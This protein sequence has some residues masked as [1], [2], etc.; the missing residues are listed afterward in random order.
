MKSS[1]EI[2]PFSPIVPGPG[3]PGVPNPAPG[4]IFRG[5]LLINLL[6]WGLLVV[7]VL[8]GEFLVLES[9]DSEEPRV[10]DGNPALLNQK[11]PFA[12]TFKI[13]LAWTALEEGLIKPETRIRCWDKHVP[14]CPG[15]IDLRTA[16]LYSSNQ[17]FV[18][19]GKKLGR[20]RIE[21][22]L[23]RGGLFAS[24]PKNWLRKGMGSV[25]SGGN[26]RISPLDQQRF[27][28]R[29]FLGDLCAPG[30]RDQLLAVMEWP[31]PRSD[32]R[33]YGKSGSAEG[34]LWFNGFG[35]L[36]GRHRFVTVFRQG[37]LDDRLQV[38]EQ[39]YQ[40]FGGGYNHALLYPPAQ[41]PAG[42][43]HLSIGDMRRQ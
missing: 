26:L 37:V 11:F 4:R 43:R 38:V 25:V 42:P 31:P 24:V 6:L 35:W 8:A 28:K 39:F 33:L 10:V 9:F 19:I 32:I 29:L 20:A 30:V 36:S 7:P 12:S 1:A 27:L 22:Y 41:L 15:E 40:R 18:V 21:D 17:Y 16:M 3:S 34:V 5:L 2:M 13:L 14:A 23:V